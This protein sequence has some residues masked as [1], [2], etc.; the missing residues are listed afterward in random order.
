MTRMERR[1]REKL[2]RMGGY[3]KGLILPRWWLRLNGDPQIIDIEITMDSIQIQPAKEEEPAHE[4][5]PS[6]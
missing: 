4:K 1:F 5:E 6:S 2:L 3:S